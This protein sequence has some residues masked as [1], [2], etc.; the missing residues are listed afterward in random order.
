M[1]NDVLTRG[2]SIE[3]MV[4]EMEAAGIDESI[5]PSSRSGVPVA[6]M[7]QRPETLVEFGIN[8]IIVLRR[9]KR[10]AAADAL[11]VGEGYTKN[12]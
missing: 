12:V 10:V 9:G 7:L 1:K 6:V 8:P 3:Q 4:D 11:M 2:T 5:I